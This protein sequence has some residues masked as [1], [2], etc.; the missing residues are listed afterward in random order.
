MDDEALLRLKRFNDEHL[1]IQKSSV[2]YENQENEILSKLPVIKFDDI[3][4]VL[5]NDFKPS[6]LYY[7]LDKLPRYFTLEIK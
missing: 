3:P 7:I 4:L 2:V 6:L 5:D 1:S